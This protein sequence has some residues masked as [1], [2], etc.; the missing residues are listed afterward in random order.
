[1][2]SRKACTILDW[3]TLGSSV[4][5][6]E[7]RRMKS[8]SD[9]PGFWVHASRSQEFPGRTYVPWKFP[10]KV[11]TRSSQLWIWLAGRC[12]SHIHTESARCSGRLQMITSSVVAPPSWHAKR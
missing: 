5:R 4:R 8:R 10:T 9:S 11:R 7:K 1:V 3:A 2:P 12:S 6:L